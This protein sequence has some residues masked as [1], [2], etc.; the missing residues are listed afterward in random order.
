MIAKNLRNSSIIVVL[1]KF[2]GLIQESHGKI[3][4]SLY[5][6]VISMINLCS[7]P[8]RALFLAKHWLHL[9]RN[10]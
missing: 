9:S 7:E 1:K 8:K 4:I 2:E 10:K 3:A 6:Q 5:F